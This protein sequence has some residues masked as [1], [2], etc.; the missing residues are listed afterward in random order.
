MTKRTFG[1]VLTLAVIAVGA[2]TSA[3]VLAYP[4]PNSPNVVAERQ[5]D[6]RLLDKKAVAASTTPSQSQQRTVGQVEDSNQ[7]I[8]DDSSAD[9]SVQ[10]DRQETTSTAT[11]SQQSPVA[12]PAKAQPSAAS[13]T[14]PK[15]DQS[16][17]GG[18]GSSLNQ[19][20]GSLLN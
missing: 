6:T 2:F 7:T 11:P 10:P 15:Q 3:L 14:P 18:V 16:L 4:N 13:Q 9:T 19:L 12:P 20:L 17:L 1:F 8:L 5:T